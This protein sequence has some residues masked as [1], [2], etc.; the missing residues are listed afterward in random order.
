M[1]LKGDADSTG[2]ATPTG[3]PETGDA[4]HAASDDRSVRESIA[5]VLAKVAIEV[6]TSPDTIVGQLARHAIGANF[7]G[8]ETDRDVFLSSLQRE[9][10]AEELCRS[11]TSR[12]AG[13]GD[14]SGESGRAGDDLEGG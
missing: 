11:R 10:E 12:Q 9:D 13:Q 8:D 6:K 3:D 1:C 7:G 14:Q 2:F 4:E 5:L